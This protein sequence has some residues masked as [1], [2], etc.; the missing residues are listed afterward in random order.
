MLV[1]VVHAKFTRKLQDRYTVSGIELNPTILHL[2]LSCTQRR[3]R[4]HKR[5]IYL[6]GPKHDQVEGEFF[7][8]KADT[9]G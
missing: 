8:H 3:F 1:V 5:R 7:L 6:K 2:E 9:Y 4:L